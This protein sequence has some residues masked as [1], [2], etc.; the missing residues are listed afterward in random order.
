MGEWQ[1]L[2]VPRNLLRIAGALTVVLA[3]VACGETGPLEGLG[4]RSSEWVQQGVAATTTTEARV[5]FEVANQGLVESANLL[6]SNDDLGNP[7]ITAGPL[8]L[9]AVWDRQIGSRFVQASRTE[10]ATALPTIRFPGLVSEDVK[11]ITSQLVFD[12]A[13]GEL[14]GTTS[15]A[16]GL[17]SVEPY[18]VSEGQLGVLR[19]GA[20]PGDVG[21]GRSDIVPILVPDGVNLGWTEGG[22]RYEMFCRASIPDAVC[23]AIIDSFVP[24]ST[25]LTS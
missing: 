24:L 15:A 25:L 23:E 12:S 13:T 3:L 14:D 4:D 20:A 22:L 16:F 21:A 18:S 2:P 1:T 11:W 19:V 7:G 6:W 17:W 9:R 8:V 5:V 10:I